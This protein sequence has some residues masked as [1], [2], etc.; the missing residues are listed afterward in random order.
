MESRS[1]CSGIPD[2]VA[3]VG[4]GAGGEFVDDRRQVLERGRVGEDGVEGGVAQ[5]PEGQGQSVRRGAVLSSSCCDRTDLAGADSQPFGVE[6]AAEVELDRGVA[7]PAQVH[8]AA[9]ADEQVERE[10]QPGGGAAGVQHD[11]LVVWSVVGEREGD[12]E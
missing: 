12:A 11:V 10:L 1:R 8:D 9:F 4:S 3:E 5:Q 2:E 6:P 7:V